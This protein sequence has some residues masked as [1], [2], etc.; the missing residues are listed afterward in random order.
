[1]ILCKLFDLCERQ[2]FP[3]LPDEV[4]DRPHG[5]LYFVMK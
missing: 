4:W 1:M 3:H 2:T 5:T